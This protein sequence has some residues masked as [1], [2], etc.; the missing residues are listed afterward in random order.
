MSAFV[1]ATLDLSDVEAGLAKLSG[2]GSRAFAAAFAALKEPLKVDQREHAKSQEGPEG[3]WAA[4]SASTMA[5]RAFKGHRAAKRPL[6]RLPTAIQYTSDASGVYGRAR[7]SWWRAIE[8]GARV[9][10]GGRSKLP[11]RVFWYLSTGVI[12]FAAKKF[13]DVLEQAWRGR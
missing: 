5:R 1:V 9:G 4:R 3:A 6:G 2:T 11:S 7:V 8:D 10:R 12:T 13:G